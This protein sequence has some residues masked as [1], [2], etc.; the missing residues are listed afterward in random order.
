MHPQ[1]SSHE[2]VSLFPRRVDSAEA[3]C[4]T[5]S[6]NSSANLRAFPQ[7]TVAYYESRHQHWKAIMSSRTESVKYPRGP[8]TALTAGGSTLGFCPTQ[9]REDWKRPEAHDITEAFGQ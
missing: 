9:E 2:C 4:H 6:R 5:S 1:K 7:L 8:N 3:V